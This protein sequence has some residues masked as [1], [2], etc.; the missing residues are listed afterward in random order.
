[1]R[2]RHL[3]LLA[4]V[5]L[6]CGASPRSAPAAVPDEG[7]QTAADPSSAG[8]DSDGGSAA[9]GAGSGLV[10]PPDGG[11]A[12]ARCGKL[13]DPLPEPVVH[14]TP[15]PRR[16]SHCGL[17]WSDGEGNVALEVT[18]EDDHP[19]WHLLSSAGTPLGSAGAWRGVLFPST[20]GYLIEQGNSAGANISPQIQGVDPGGTLRQHT[21]VHGPALLVP[22]QRGELLVLGPVMAD[23]AP[24][25]ATFP[26]AAW[27][28]RDD[29]TTLWGPRPLP[30]QARIVGGGIDATGRALVLQDGAAAFGPGTTA[31]QWFDRD[32]A[33]LTSP[34]VLLDASA[35]GPPAGLETSPL[36]GGGL[37]VRRVS[38]DSASGLETSE[39]LVVVASGRPA[40]A[41]APEWLRSR[42]NT[43]LAAISGGRYALLP[44]GSDVSPCA[45]A[46]DIVSAAGASCTRVVFAIDGGKCRTRD[47]RRGLDGTV[48]QMLPADRERFVQSPDVYACTLRFWPAALR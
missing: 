24:P 40:A 46:V 32:G 3:A 8:G 11:A 23:P 20:H 10:P 19:R 4:L 44:L 2:D 36:I 39:W 14:A 43:T 35:A 26:W 41:P 21:A 17:A 48:L 34:F 7:S 42:P 37:A 29:A 12:P 1:M 6:A 27:V 33:A 28:L 18:D 15:Y 5:S 38:L 22:S 30:M 25:L 47:L 45:Q 9:G 13:A 31:A 16:L